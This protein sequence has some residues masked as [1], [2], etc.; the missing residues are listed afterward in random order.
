MMLYA[1]SYTWKKKKTAELTQSNMANLESI[2]L[3]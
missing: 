1:T 2:L 3:L